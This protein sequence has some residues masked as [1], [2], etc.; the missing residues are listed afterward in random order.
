MDYQPALPVP[1][2]DDEL[3]ERLYTEGPQTAEEYLLWVR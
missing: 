1:E 2:A 3:I